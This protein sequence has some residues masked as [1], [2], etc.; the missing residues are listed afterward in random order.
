MGS[1]THDAPVTNTYNALSPQNLALGD[2]TQ[3]G[4]PNILNQQV[5]NPFQ[6]L[7]PGTSLNAATVAAAATAAAVPGVH[8]LEPA[9]YSGRERSGTTRCR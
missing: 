7:L 6:G 1:R 9:E 5:P 8:R 3:G 4:N 2:V